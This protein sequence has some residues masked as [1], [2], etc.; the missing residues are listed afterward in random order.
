MAQ[1]DPLPELKI[2]G[3]DDEIETSPIKRIEN[4]LLCSIKGINIKIKDIL[5]LCKAIKISHLSSLSPLLYKLQDALTIG[6]EISDLFDQY[7]VIPVIGF[8]MES[9]VKLCDT[10]IM[11]KKNN[12]DMRKVLRSVEKVCN[13][14]ILGNADELSL[15][16]GSLKA[17]AE[18]KVLAKLYDVAKYL[19]MNEIGDNSL[20]IKVVDI[21]NKLL[22][23]S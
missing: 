20:I 3:I 23:K 15:L 4:I 13:T 11:D 8:E 17:E 18:R 19:T 16:V 21:I 2:L 9:L 14:E 12:S 22:T 7:K 10:G 5:F 1:K 6:E